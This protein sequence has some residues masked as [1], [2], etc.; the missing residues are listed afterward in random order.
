MASYYISPTGDDATGTGTLGN[1]WQTLAKF[2]AASANGD[3]C[4]CLDGS[5]SFVSADINQR[6]IVADHSGLAIF[7][8]GVNEAWDLQKDCQFEGLRFTSLQWNLDNDWYLFSGNNDVYTATWINC[9]FNDIMVDGGAGIFIGARRG[10]DINEVTLQGCL[11]YNI[12]SNNTG[13]ED[14]IFGTVVRD[15]TFNILN[16]T[17]YPKQGGANALHKI[18]NEKFQTITAVIKNTII[19]NDTGSTIAMYNGAF[20]TF[21]PTA[22]YSDFYQI[23]NSPSGT[24]VI[25]SD[26]LFVDPANDN[27]YLRQGSPCI[28]TGALF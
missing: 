27:F 1:P 11:L 25:T 9:I 28:D 20:G 24:G 7:T 22:S 15:A 10:G 16:T 17:I 19:M 5:Y 13:G 23:A 14:C 26:P 6:E 21:D 2:L 18:F 8:G 4:V 12:Y 3:T